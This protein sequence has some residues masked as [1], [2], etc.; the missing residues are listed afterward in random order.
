MSDPKTVSDLPI[1]VSIRWANDQKLLQEAY[2]II[3]DS[4]SISQFTQKDVSSP[5]S[6][7]QLDLLLNVDNTSP[8]WA[9]FSAP[10]GFF[11]QRKLLFTSRVLPLFKSEDDINNKIDRI[12]S[13]LDKN[14]LEESL[15]EGREQKS[16]ITMLEQLRT[17]NKN[18]LFIMSRRNQ[19]QKG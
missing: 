9:L 8:T 11:D 1:D 18:L 10:A 19:Y 4:K 15:G 17:I 13:A 2:P 16:L 5:A 14:E 12:I 6:Q 3:A 7:S